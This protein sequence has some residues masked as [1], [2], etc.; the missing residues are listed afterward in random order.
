MLTKIK[1][2]T[3]ALVGLIVFGVGHAAETNSGGIVY[4]YTLYM[5]WYDS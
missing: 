4:V 2:L 3:V 1:A 5:V